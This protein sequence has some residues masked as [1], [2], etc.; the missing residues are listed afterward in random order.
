MSSSWREGCPVPLTALS[1]LTLSYRG[2]D[3][4]PHIGEL[5][6]ATQV[7]PAVVS[8]FHRLFDAGFPIRSMRL[9][10]DFAGSD[11]ASMAAD[12]TSAFNCRLTAS[13]AAYS[14]HAYGLAVDINPLEN[15]YVS[16]GQVEPAAGREFLDRPDR[17]G[18]I[19]DGDACVSAFGSVGWSWGG[20]WSDPKDYQHFSANGH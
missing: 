2:L 3:G 9:V 20:Y 4:R 16:G 18:V 19:H 15:P 13:G 17:P 12:N 7:A 11:N 14:Q 8:A 5:V 1:Y 6:V 10:D